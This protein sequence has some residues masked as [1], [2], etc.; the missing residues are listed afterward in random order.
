M[1]LLY[2]LPLAWRGGSE[3]HWWL[4]IK[5]IPKLHPKIRQLALDFGAAVIETDVHQ[6]VD[7]CHVIVHDKWLNRTNGSGLVS[8]STF[9]YL[10][11]LDWGSWFSQEFPGTKVLTLRE[12]LL[13]LKEKNAYPMLEFKRGNP[14][15]FLKYLSELSEE[16]IFDK[17]QLLLFTKKHKFINKFQDSPYQNNLLTESDKGGIFKW[18]W[19]N[20]TTKQDCRIMLKMS[21]AKGRRLFVHLKPDLDTKEN[22]Q[23][24]VQCR[25]DYVITEKLDLLDQLVWE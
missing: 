3:K 20:E 16:G 21:H 25:A 13:F 14:N 22:L 9:S 24:V 23:Q 11:T 7:G 1:L 19:H 6:T 4:P 5:A 17:D 2:S 10:Q 18:K 12:A 15:V 8:K